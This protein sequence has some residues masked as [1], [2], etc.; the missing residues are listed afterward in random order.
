MG[1]VDLP[2]GSH[3]GFTDAGSGLRVVFL[4]PTP[5]DREFWRPLTHELAGIRAI[6]PDLRGHG[7]SDLGAALPAGGF[8][9]VPDAPVRRE[10]SSRVKKSPAR[11]RFAAGLPVSSKA[12]AT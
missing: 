11:R 9:R 2:D 10:R 8:A 6:L 3:L 12:G 4:H 5:V 1:S 7:A